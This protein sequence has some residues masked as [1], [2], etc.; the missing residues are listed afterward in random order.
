VTP[1]LEPS[2]A[3]MDEAALAR[4]DA[5]VQADIDAGRHFGASLLVARGGRIVHRADL[6]T[7]SRPHDPEHAVR[8]RWNFH[9][10]RRL[11]SNQHSLAGMGF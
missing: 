9:W 11:D 10:C 2:D 8:Q 7:G 3:G 1:T 6:G 5:A 4:F